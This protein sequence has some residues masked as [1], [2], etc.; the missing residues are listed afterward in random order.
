MA[1]NSEATIAKNVTSFGQLITRYTD[2]GAGYSPGKVAYKLPAL[3]TLK[4]NAAAAHEALGVQWVEYRR[5]VAERAAVFK[6]LAKLV[7]RCLNIFLSSDALPQVKNG[8]K[9]LADKVRGVDTSKSPPPPPPGGMPQED[10][11][12]TVQQSYVMR[13]EN[14]GLFV[15]M[16]R[17]EPSYLPGKD[18]LKL[19]ALD[20]LKAV[21]DTKYTETDTAFMMWKSRLNARDTLFFTEDMGLVDIALATKKYVLG[22]FG[23][24]SQEYLAVK[25]IRFYRKR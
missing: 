19:P 15:E 24:S 25:P 4:T 5:V 23:S 18:D 11:H 10:S 17:A 20:A 6:P 16:L 7:T 12:S 13:A 3:N 14:F 8:A 1:S 21:F 2:M 22:D 9:A